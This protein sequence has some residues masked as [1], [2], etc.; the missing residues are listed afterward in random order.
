MG[1]VPN[2]IRKALDE[3][4]NDIR[5][6]SSMQKRKNMV[7]RS[8]G[9]AVVLIVIGVMATNENVQASFTQLF[10]SNDRG[11]QLAIDE[12][13][14]ND[15]RATIS[16]ESIRITKEQHFYDGRKLGISLSIL[17][18]EWTQLENIVEVTLDYRLVNGD[19]TYL[20]E[21]IPDTKP[22]KGDGL[23][24]FQ[25]GSEQSKLNTSDGRVEMELLFS[26]IGEE[27]SSI[28]DSIFIFKIETIKLWH[29]DGTFSSVDG[30]WNIPLSNMD[31]EYTGDPVPYKASDEDHSIKIIKATAYP[32]SLFIQ[33]EMEGDHSAEFLQITILTEDDERY[34]I[35]GYRVEVTDE[36]TTVISGNFPLSLFED[37]DDLTLQIAGIG[38]VM[39]KKQR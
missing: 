24:S 17:F 11:A 29:E 36:E 14:V 38:E 22:L 35:G 12:G 9:A 10:F 3:T 37:L 23:H 5:E 34:E 15:D 31:E 28:H 20:L 21:M 25:V 18:D 27:I 16:D 2:H 13:F 6:K 7:Q 26:A 19:G 39:L 1:N 33:F 4:Y 32:T 8:I 30:E